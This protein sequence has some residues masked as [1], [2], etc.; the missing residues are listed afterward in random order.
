MANDGKT[1][2]FGNG[3]GGARGGGARPADLV[4]NPPKP[5]REERIQPNPQSIPEG[6]TSPFPAID[7]NAG[8]P[9]KQ[10]GASVG[11]PGSGTKPFRV[12]GG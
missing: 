12:G 1:S 9:A 3:Q 5:A 11:K 7:R 4:T 2:P 10:S 6:G 8:G